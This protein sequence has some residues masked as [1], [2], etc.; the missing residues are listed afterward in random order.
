MRHFLVFFCLV[1]LTCLTLPLEVYGESPSTSKVVEIRVE[2]NNQMSEG[3][4]LANVRTRIGSNYDEATVKTDQ[5]RLLDTG[6][7]E[8]VVTSSR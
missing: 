1:L 4:I 3:A 7:F 2:G 8:S 5:G 6:R